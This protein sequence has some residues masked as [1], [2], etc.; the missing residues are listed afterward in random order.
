VTS[1]SEVPGGAPGIAPPDGKVAPILE[2]RD[3]RMEFNGVHALD[4]V[5]VSVGRGEIVGLVGPNGS[6]KSTLINVLTG[7]F[8]P[9]GGR[10]VFEGSDITG[11]PPHVVSGLGIARTYQIPRPFES[12]T[13][14]ENVAFSCMFRSDGL[15]LS[16]ALQAA[17]EYLEFTGLSGVARALPSQ[18]NLHQRKF[19]ELA[20]ALATKP[21]L[22]MLDEVLSGL[23]PTE[24]DESVE[25]IRKIHASNVTLV[26]VEHVMRVVTQLASR[27]MVLNYGRLLAE[28]LPAEVMGDPDVVKAYLG[29]RHA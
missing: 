3:I 23:N 18:I 16:E 20:R 21:K 5:T 22:L 28:G 19:L 11:E 29:K 24:I 1:R 9:T 17:G 26:I 7:M 15:A 12:M 25:M 27:M 13:V 8:V 14:L 10:V 6:G 2:S 4:G